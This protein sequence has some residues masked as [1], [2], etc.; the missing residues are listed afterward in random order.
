M[1]IYIYI[2]I[3]NQP[4]SYIYIY[5]YMCIRASVGRVQTSSCQRPRRVGRLTYIMPRTSRVA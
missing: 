2:Y 3:L 1:Y 4:I 5:I